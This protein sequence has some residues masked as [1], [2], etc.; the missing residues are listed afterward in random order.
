MAL[1]SSYWPADHSVEVAEMTVGD[2]LRSAAASTPD[3]V[4]LVAGDSDP[5]SRR[6][7][8]YAA[9]LDESER[10]ACALLSR[11]APGEHVAVWSPSLPQWEMLQMAAG[12]AGL[13]LVTVNPALRPREVEYI[14]RQSQAAGIAVVR[15]FRGNPLAGVVDEIRPG[16]PGLREV[17]AFEDWDGFVTTAAGD[18]ALPAVHPGDPAM[19]QYTSGTTGA[20]KGALLSHRGVVNNARL[21][22]RRFRLDECPVWVNPL[23][24]F[25]VGGCVFSALGALWTGPTHVLVPAFDPALVLELIDSERG[26][27]LPAVPTM[28]VA[29]L[30]HPDLED[31]DVSSLRVVMSGGTTVPAELVKQVQARFGAAYGIVFGQTETSGVITLSHPQDSVA[32]T[33]GTVGQPIEQTEV[34]VVDPETGATLPP[35][36]VGELC[37]RGFGVMLGYYD[38]PEATTEA[39]DP[40]GWLHTGDLGSMDGRGYCR[41]TGRLKDMIIRGGEN[42][43]PR[44]IE[45]VLFT[46]PGVAE[47]AVVGV[48]DPKWGEQ[49]AAFVRPAGAQPPGP[50]ELRAFAQEHLAAH[51]VPRHWRFVDQLPVTA[52]GKVQ[53]FVL[54]QQFESETG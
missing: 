45:D 6:R 35:D 3:R 48:A 26:S 37:V 10:A 38:M 33:A 34:K 50:D 9:L 42:I 52:S 30:E 43:Y 32:D 4:A 17:I 54:R 12:L 40:D 51:K 41:I 47:V 14:L 46:H 27:F 25:H 11:F 23:P 7:L 29:M 44:E 36:Q 2:L 1:T 19:I 18:A 49:V 16:L 39:I 24:M 5:G 28:L 8:T 53:K 15:E 21:F 20:P 22:S 31:R 13:V